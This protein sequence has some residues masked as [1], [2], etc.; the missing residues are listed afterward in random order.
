MSTRRCVLCGEAAGADYQTFT[1][2][3]EVRAIYERS[4]LGGDVDS[5]LAENVFCAGC[6]ALPAHARAALARDAITREGE[7][8][9]KDLSREILFKRIDIARSID[10][11]AL[12]EGTW[13]WLNLI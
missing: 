10:T 4:F 3:P 6:R 9:R 12:T 2:T 1:I 8:Y 5:L 13:D 7:A 11:V